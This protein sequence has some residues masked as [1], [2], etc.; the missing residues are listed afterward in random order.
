MS[1]S[2][3]IAVSVN[4]HVLQAALQHWGAASASAVPPV[5]CHPEQQHLARYPQMG[6]FKFCDIKATA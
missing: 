4:T 5:D 2:A 3:T 6:A 1:A